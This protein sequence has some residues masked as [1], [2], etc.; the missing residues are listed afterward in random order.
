MG[1]MSTTR[2]RLTPE[3]RREQLLELGTRLFAT[4][5]LDELSIDLLAEEAGISRG[6]LYHYFANKQEFHRAVIERAV[7]K[8]VEATA[9]LEVGEP[10]ERLVGSIEAYIDYVEANFKGYQSLVQAA[11]GG[12][13]VIRSLYDDAR[14]QLMD[15]MFVVAVG[16]SAMDEYGFQ[17]NPATRLVLDAWSSFAES[18]VLGWVGAGKPMSRDQL[19]AV[20]V[21]G[22]PAMLEATR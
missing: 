2:I 11:F 5:T 18:L 7:E 17:D 21:G 16:T 8:L 1:H 3:A 4:R 19:I 10:I 12:D 6:L 15:R 22:L 9:P 13:P 14:K 20:L